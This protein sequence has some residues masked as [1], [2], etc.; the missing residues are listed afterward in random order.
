MRTADFDEL[1]R[2]A[3]RFRKDQLT[4]PE[5][6]ASVRF[7]DTLARA[8]ARQGAHHRRLGAVLAAGIRPGECL[9]ASQARFGCRSD[10]GRQSLAELREDALRERGNRPS[11][12]RRPAI[13]QRTVTRAEQILKEAAAQPTRDSAVFP[14]CCCAAHAGADRVEMDQILD[15]GLQISTKNYNLYDVMANYLLDHSKGKHGELEKF[16][17]AMLSRLGGEDGLDIYGRMA[18]D[19]KQFDVTRGSLHYDGEFATRQK[20]NSRPPCQSWSSGMQNH[21][22]R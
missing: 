15:R 12:A 3:E 1:E 17:D 6:F 22:S 11:Y 14:C 8:R 2:W 13:V 5:G 10:R 9:V 20:T 19:C 4:T 21:L 16:A 7:Y 18:L